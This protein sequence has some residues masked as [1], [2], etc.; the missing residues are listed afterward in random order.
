MWLVFPACPVYITHVKTG[1]VAHVYKCL[2][3]TSPMYHRS[4]VAVPIVSTV[5]MKK[6]LDF[7]ICILCKVQ[8]IVKIDI[9]QTLDGWL[10]SWL[11]L[12]IFPLTFSKVFLMLFIILTHH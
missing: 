1:L 12:R 3:N 6:Y 2:F 4:A 8:M 5:T 10:Y 7:D 11:L 9:Y